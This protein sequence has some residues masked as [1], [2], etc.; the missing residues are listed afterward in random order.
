LCANVLNASMMPAE[1]GAWERLKASNW[2]E[3]WVIKEL[4]LNQMVKC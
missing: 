2:S 4:F 1:H 3:L